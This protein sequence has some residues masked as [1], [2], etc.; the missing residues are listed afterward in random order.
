M[1]RKLKLNQLLIYFG[2]YIIPFVENLSKI[3]QKFEI[4]SENIVKDIFKILMLKAKITH[5]SDV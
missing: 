5:N 1:Y 3:L 4:K 2:I